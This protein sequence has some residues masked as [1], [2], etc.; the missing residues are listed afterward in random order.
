MMNVGNL[1]SSPLSCI[2]GSPPPSPKGLPGAEMMVTRH[3]LERGESSRVAY[4]DTSSEEEETPNVEFANRG[5]MIEVEDLFRYRHFWDKEIVEWNYID[6]PVLD[7]LG[8]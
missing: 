3:T 4:E 7:I 6:T 5:L 1:F 8:I 2:C